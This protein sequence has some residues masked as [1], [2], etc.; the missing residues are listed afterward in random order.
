MIDSKSVSK[1]MNIRRGIIFG[2]V[3]CGTFLVAHIINAVIAE[4]LSVPG[5]LVRRL[6]GSSREPEVSA[7]LP[8]LVQ[9]IRT[10]G[11]LP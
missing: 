10:S 1:T 8:V 11:L 7:T 4:A 2:Y 5:G 6:P 3:I 9:R